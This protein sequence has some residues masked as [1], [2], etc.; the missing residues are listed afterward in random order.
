MLSLYKNN[1]SGIPLPNYTYNLETKTP[2]IVSTTTETTTTFTPS[3]VKYN[4]SFFY[5]FKDNFYAK[6]LTFDSYDSKGNLLQYHKENDIP[7]SYIWGYNNT[8]P[9]AKIDNAE[10]NECFYTSFEEDPG[11]YA[12]HPYTFDS[13]ISKTGDVS[14][15]S[16]KLTSGENYFYLP[17]LSINNSTSKTYKYSVWVYSTA[18][19]ADLYCFHQDTDDSYLGTGWQAASKRTTTKNSWVLLEGEI[20]VPSNKK[21][22]YLRVDNNGGGTV[23]FDE[24]RLSPKDAQMS[25]YTYDPLIGMTSETDPNGKTTYYVYDTFGR[26]Y[27]IKDQDDNILKQYEYNYAH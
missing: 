4:G 6:H 16:E 25:T 13:N 17:M 2:L 10:Y 7:V 22:I 3:Q 9:T 15:K 26:L 23:W 21:C 1:S 14:L 12:W 27:Q 5:L 19:S 18:V 11:I 20:V 8:Y 24:L